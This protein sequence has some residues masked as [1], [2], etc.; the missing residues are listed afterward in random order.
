M[1]RDRAGIV[2][3]A[4]LVEFEPVLSGLAGA[5]GLNGQFLRADHGARH[6]VRGEVGDLAVPG[7]LAAAQ[8]RHFVGE[9][10]DLAELVRDHQDGQFAGHDHG[11]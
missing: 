8:D 1:D 11:A 2:K 10:H 4:E 9:R 7:E 3:R 5:G 6:V